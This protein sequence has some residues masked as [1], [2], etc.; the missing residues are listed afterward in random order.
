MNLQDL[1]SVAEIAGGTATLLTLIY[2]AVQVRENTSLS[3]RTALENYV[4]RLARWW[5]SLGA[6]PE[7]LSIY[8]EGDNDFRSLDEL[9]K[10]RYHYLKLEIMAYMETA[11]EHGKARGFKEATLEATL[12]AIK[13]EMSK[14]GSHQWWHEMGKEVFADDFSIK[15]E[16][17]V[18]VL[19]KS[20]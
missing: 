16:S 2:L 17:L 3:K 4:D 6:D 13:L 19:V 12:R 15:V 20:S 10:S 11:L 8:L 14:P 7:L 9:A 18:P 1:A 5:S